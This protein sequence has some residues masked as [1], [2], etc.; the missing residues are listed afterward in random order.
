MKKKFVYI[1]S[2]ILVVILLFISTLRL[3]LPHAASYMLEKAINGKAHIDEVGV[4]FKGRALK[5]DITGIRLEG[6]IDGTVR[7]VQVSAGIK[8]GLYLNSLILSDFNLSI[9][10]RKD[11][12]TRFFTLPAEL[13]QIKKGIVQ[14]GSY[15]IIIN[16][17]VVNNLAY[18]KPFTFHMDI[19]NDYYFQAI[20][21]KGE[22]IYRRRGFELKGDAEVYS[23]RGG[24]L[25]DSIKGS[26]SARCSF[27]YEK[28]ILTVTGPVEARDFSLKADFLSRPILMKKINGNISLNY[29]DKGV[30]IAVSG[31]RFKDTPFDVRINR[32]VKGT[33][34]ITVRSGFIDMGDIKHYLSLEGISKK[35]EEAMNSIKSGRA[36]LNRLVY[37]K[38]SPFLCDMDINDVVILYNE[39]EIKDIDGHLIIDDTKAKFNNLQGWFR[40]SRFSNIDGELG[41]A[42]SKDI[43]IKGNFFVNLPDIPTKIDLGNLK[44]KDGFSEGSFEFEKKDGERGYS[45]KGNG[46][47]LRSK[48][49]YNNF[50]VHAKGLYRFNRD[51]IEFDPLE[52][53]KDKTSIKIKGRWRR[54]FLGIRILGRLD[55]QHIK[56]FIKIPFNVSGISV[57]DMEVKKKDDE[58]QVT[59]FVNMDNLYYNIK[60]YILKNRGV[61]NTA[62]LMVAKKNR[63]IEVKHL[64]YSLEGINL[65][66]TGKIEKDVARDIHVTLNVLDIE[67]RDHIFS[68][69]ETLTKGNIEMDIMVKEL[70]FS[71][72]KMPLIYGRLEIKNGYIKIPGIPSP[73]SEVNL[74]SRF[75]GDKI[76]VKGNRIRCGKSLFNSIELQSKGIEYPNF[77]LSADIENFDYSDFETPGDIVI[78]AIK[79]DNILAKAKGEISITAKKARI[80]NK[81]GSNVLV[82]AVYGD[83]RINVSEIR[84]N[85]L[86]GDLEGYGIADLSGDAPRIS[87]TGR[88]KGI[89]SGEF[90]K[91]FGATTHV[92]ESKEFIF[93]D[94]NF[95]GH[96]I[97]DFTRTLSGRATIYSE[98]GV[99]KKMNLLSK[100]FG[101]LN[102]YELLRGRVDFKSEGF[103]YKKTGANFVIDNGVF[104]TDDY[105]IDSPAMVITGQGSLNL[106]DKTMK[107]KIA[108]SPLVTLDK[109]VSNIPMLKNILRDKERGFIYAVY[110]VNG[111]IEDP[112][113]KTGYIQTIGSLPLNILKGMIEFPMNLFRD[114]SA[115]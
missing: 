95:Y 113:I 33:E 76:Y 105:I 57:V 72:E 84:A 6:D 93:V 7:S 79:P 43:K 4:R 5:I 58:T 90:L 54:G 70:F 115:R 96:T 3:V 73:L 85:A 106:V 49:L 38:T 65:M 27:R 36:R 110:D 25:T 19:Q 2:G 23:L 62:S 40:K 31:V 1:F 8:K 59:G 82:K 91:M 17:I 13:V 107:A 11:T 86:D 109:V 39:M 89:S 50:P 22:G 81:I 12:K 24:L 103:K 9:K 44:F 92:I 112:E 69:N 14:Y 80:D 88:M 48:V 63:V 20:K 10:K 55:S 45:L 60:N 98:N 101:L 104:R 29:C 100:I 51:E 114:N 32:G 94:L 61:K 68:F 78:Y 53:E 21:A 87:L 66:L 83:R 30:D 28:G 34:I 35:A 64:D 74:I 46:R 99:I 52:I 111:P 77:I 47:L 37:S 26:I 18:K 42:G 67:K 75:D 97:D 102:V 16:E 56:P 71:L 15:K 108:V 41:F